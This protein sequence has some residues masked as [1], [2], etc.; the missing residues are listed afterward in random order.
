[1]S[2]PITHNIV[3]CSDHAGFAL[4]EHLKAVLEGQGITVTDAGCYSADSVDYPK[5]VETA[6]N[7]MK[8]TQTEYG[9]FICGSG[10]GV[11]IGANRYPHLRATIAHDV[12][13]AVMSRRHN[14]TNVLCL[15][16]R[17]IAT[18]RAEEIL[19]AWLREPFEANHHT[20]RVDQLSELGKPQ[21]AC[22]V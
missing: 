17:V 15:G 7:Q 14:D 8:D 20:L 22:S 16:A 5:V 19:D 11:M 9:L 21:S 12:S 18:P 3:V 13:T 10:V 6:V 2:H 4:K 1:M